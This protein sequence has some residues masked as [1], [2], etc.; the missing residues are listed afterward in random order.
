MKQTAI[1]NG[2]VLVIVS[3]SPALV[4]QHLD[5]ALAKAA[6]TRCHAV[7]R[8]PRPRLLLE[9]GSIGCCRVVAERDGV[10]VRHPRGHAVV[11]AQKDLASQLPKRRGVRIA[12]RATTTV[13]RL[14]ARRVTDHGE[15]HRVKS[16]P[17]V[18]RRRSA[19]SAN[20]GRPR[21]YGCRP[22]PYKSRSQHVQGFGTGGDGRPVSMRHHPKCLCCRGVRDD[23]AVFPRKGHRGNQLRIGA[24]RLGGSERGR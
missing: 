15:G 3:G 17:Q 13:I 6:A 1:R 21:R 16:A 2:G 5:E 20:T 10:V 12:G 19:Q 23:G 8:R 4:D 14:G 24:I 11:E 9:G 22:D 18:S 7:C